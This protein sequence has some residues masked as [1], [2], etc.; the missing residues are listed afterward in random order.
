MKPVIDDDGDTL[1]S[2]FWKGTKVKGE[3]IP[4]TGYK[5]YEIKDRRQGN[6]FILINLTFKLKLLMYL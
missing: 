5:I 4:T 1:T 3:Y 2:F 6:K